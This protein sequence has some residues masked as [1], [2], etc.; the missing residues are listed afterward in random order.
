MK[1]L[2]AS[3]GWGEDW[4]T[5]RGKKS[6]SH[7]HLQIIWNNTTSGF[8]TS[9]RLSAPVTSMSIVKNIQR[10]KRHGYRQKRIKINLSTLFTYWSQSLLSSCYQ[11]LFFIIVG[12]T[13]FTAFTLAEMYQGLS[14]KESLQNWKF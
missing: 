12:V 3:P 9:G 7:K 13:S 2:N 5:G 10:K 1:T 11:H 6:Q 4:R 8:H 14:I